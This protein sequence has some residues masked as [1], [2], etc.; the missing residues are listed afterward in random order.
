VGTK[1]SVITVNLNNSA[2]LQRTVH[3]VLAQDFSDFE[4]LVIDGGSTDGSR[5]LLEKNTDPRLSWISEPD[6]GIYDAMNKGINK[7]TGEYL[8]FLNSGDRL[9]RKS[10][11]KKISKYLS[12]GTDIVYGNM[13]ISNNGV[14][15]NGFMP[16]QIDAAQMVRD[17]LWHP[18]SFIRKDLFMKYGLYDTS[19]RITGDYEFFFRVIIGKGVSTRHVGQYI[20]VFELNGLSS[21]LRN[22]NVIRDEKERV[23]KSYFSESEIDEIKSRFQPVKKKS[24]FSRWFR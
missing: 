14:I 8:L 20:S 11:L 17:T 10:T 7:A 21:D 13:K 22:V 24:I 12:A 2:G 18:V 23:Q 4:H 1:I 5:E 19:Y 15:T 6:K 9:F 3:S 16:D